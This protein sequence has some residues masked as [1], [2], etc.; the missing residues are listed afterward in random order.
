MTDVLH[1]KRF[2]TVGPHMMWL[3]AA[4]LIAV[5]LVLTSFQLMIASPDLS[6]ID[7]TLMFQL[8]RNITAGQWLGEYNWLTLSKHSFFALWLAVVHMLGVNFLVAGQALYA[9]ACAL[10]LSAIRPLVKSCAARLCV[11]AAVL[12]TPATWSA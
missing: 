12:Y 7:D 9:A 11:F 2:P 3:L 1:Q 4:F 10:L 5:K 8:A 6:P